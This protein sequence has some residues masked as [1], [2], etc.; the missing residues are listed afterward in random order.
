V[1]AH[2][3]FTELGV[4]GGAYAA[5]VAGGVGVGFNADVVVSPASVMKIQVALAV[6]SAA[7]LGRLHGGAK[8]PLSVRQL[9]PLSPL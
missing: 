6:E 4:F 8:G 9:A 3:L 2:P 5:P 1:E 7:V